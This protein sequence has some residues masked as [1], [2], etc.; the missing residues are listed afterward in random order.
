MFNYY[1]F[2]QLGSKRVNS[3]ENDRDTLSRGNLIVILAPKKIIDVAVRCN[4]VMSVKKKKLLSLS[5]VVGVTRR[6]FFFFVLT[7]ECYLGSKEDSKMEVIV[8]LE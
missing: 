7:W 5:V 4:I 6:Q 2:F 8:A 1:L 3:K